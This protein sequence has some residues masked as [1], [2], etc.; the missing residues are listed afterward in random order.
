[1]YTY[2]EKDDDSIDFLIEIFI[3]VRRHYQD[4]SD[5]MIRMTMRSSLHE[6]LPEVIDILDNS[7]MLAGNNAINRTLEGLAVIMQ[8]KKSWTGEEA[9]EL[10]R[11]AIAA[12]DQVAEARIH[13]GKLN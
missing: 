2:E 6:E 12:G 5:E 8:R 1:M 7:V 9:A 11:A 13:D 4:Q 3:M 10:M